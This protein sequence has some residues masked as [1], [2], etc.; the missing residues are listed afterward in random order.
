MDADLTQ[1]PKYIFDY[2]S[3]KTGAPGHPVGEISLT[4]EGKKKVK[5]YSKG[6]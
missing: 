1:D 6:K 4:S 2:D 3:V 5:F